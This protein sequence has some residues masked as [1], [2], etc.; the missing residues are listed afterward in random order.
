M[1]ELIAFILLFSLSTVIAAGVTKLFFV[2]IQPG[3]LFEGWNK[4]LMKLEPKRGEK[5]FFIKHVWYRWLGG[6][7]TCTRFFFG[8][9]SFAMMC[10]IFSCYGD[11]PTTYIDMWPVR[12]I[13]NFGMFVGF[14]GLAMIVGQ[15]LE[16]RKDEHDSETVI[17]TIYN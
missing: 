17:E 2:L 6:C 15:L 16:E 5:Y 7:E 12:W 1:L 13:A 9:L 8:M 4:V 10:L 3:E 11:F 14:T